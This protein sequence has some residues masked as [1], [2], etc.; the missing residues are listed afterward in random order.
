[1]TWGY[2]REYV[3]R[4]IFK[5]FCSFK[6]HIGILLDSRSGLH[7]RWDLRL[8]LS[9]LTLDSSVDIACF[10]MKGSL[11]MYAHK[12]ISHKVRGPNRSENA[13]HLLEWVYREWCVHILY[14]FW[15]Y[16]TQCLCWFCTAKASYRPPLHYAMCSLLKTQHMR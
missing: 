9:Q 5:P 2:M 11:M 8:C 4:Q 1:M 7:T 16:Y 12:E 14:A 13:R 3:H 10:S 6:L 15:A